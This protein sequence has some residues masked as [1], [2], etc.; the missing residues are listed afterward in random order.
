MYCMKYYQLKDLKNS[1][2]RVFPPKATIRTC[3]I[4][5]HAPKDLAEHYQQVTHIFRSEKSQLA[6]NIRCYER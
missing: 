1:S 3:Q 2:T 6:Q 4:L 5:H